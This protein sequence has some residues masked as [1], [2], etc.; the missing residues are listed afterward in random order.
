MAPINKPAFNKVT[1]TTSRGQQKIGAHRPSLASTGA[2]HGPAGAGGGA[3]GAGGAAASSSGFPKTKPSTPRVASGA[4][5]GSASPAISVRRMTIGANR[6][7]AEPPSAIAG[8]GGP[9]P[10]TH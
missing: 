8:H 5:S 1:P 4:G 6:P 10:S 7:G 9:E 2:P 3:G